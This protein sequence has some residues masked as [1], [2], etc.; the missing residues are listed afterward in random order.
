M[1]GFEAKR[2]RKIQRKQKFMPYKIAIFNL[3][4]FAVLTQ[5]CKNFDISKINTHYIKSCICPKNR[6]IRYEAI[7][8]QLVFTIS[9]Q[10]P[11]FGCKLAEK[12]DEADDVTF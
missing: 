11:I 12:P 9:K 8:Q 6:N 3:E 5:Q 7:Y 1:Y 2:K 4:K 10:Y